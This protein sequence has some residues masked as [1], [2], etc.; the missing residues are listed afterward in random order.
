MLNNRAPLNT[1]N[2]HNTKHVMRQQ[3]K[4]GNNAHTWFVHTEN[5]WSFH[6]SALLLS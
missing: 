3:I 2:V 1:C 6:Q 4:E 5:Q